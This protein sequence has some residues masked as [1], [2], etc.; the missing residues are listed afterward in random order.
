MTDKRS[1]SQILFGYLPQQ[2][3]DVRGG[4]WKVESWRGALSEGNVDELS[5]RRE[6]CRIARPWQASGKDGDFVRDIEQRGIGIQVKSLDR[7]RG[8][9]LRP[10]PRIWFCRLCRR[11]YHRPDV[12]CRCGSAERK[13]QLQFVHYCENCA[14]IREPYIPACSEHQESRINFPGTASGSEVVF[15]CPIC[16]RRLRE[17]FGFPRS[18]C[19]AAMKVNVHRASS[20]YTPRY[21]VI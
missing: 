5:L 9:E 12:R 1:V 16:R 11:I 4:I 3:V 20:V 17:G 2:T 21:V 6:L 14:E 7:G 10:F 19:G 18:T 13:G 15:D 8:V